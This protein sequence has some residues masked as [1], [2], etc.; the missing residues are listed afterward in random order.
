MEFSAARAVSELH[1][2]G[3]VVSLGASLSSERSLTPLILLHQFINSEGP[4]SKRKAGDRVSL[5]RQGDEHEKD[6]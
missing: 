5:F 4:D 3:W 1:D 2:S 6:K